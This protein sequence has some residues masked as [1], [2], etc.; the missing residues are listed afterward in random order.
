LI[1]T[2]NQLLWCRGLIS[3]RRVQ[4]QPPFGEC[5]LPFFDIRLTSG[6]SLAIGQ[7]R[8]RDRRFSVRL[9]HVIEGATV[10][11]DLAARFTL[12]SVQLTEAGA[13]VRAREVR[14]TCAGVA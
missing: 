4:S 14:G 5:A 2:G 8:G 10:T 7:V 13:A 9:F 1:D 11:K 6:V 12:F 3:H